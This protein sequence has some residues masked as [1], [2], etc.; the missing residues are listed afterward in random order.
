MKLRHLNLPIVTLFTS[1]ANCT[2]ISVLSGILLAA[3][4]VTKIGHPMYDDDAVRVD[5]SASRKSSQAVPFGKHRCFLEQRVTGSPPMSQPIYR[6][7]QWSSVRL[8]TVLHGP[9]RPRK[10]PLAEYYTAGR[11]SLPARLSGPSTFDSEVTM[12]THSLLLIS[13][14]LLVESRLLRNRERQRKTD[15]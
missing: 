3:F 13:A 6:F 11:D 7:S 4:T 15:Q 9:R 14:D 12:T 8:W 10:R 2:V 5:A 1:I